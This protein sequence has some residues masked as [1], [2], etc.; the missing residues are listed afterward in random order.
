MLADMHPDVAK[1]VWKYGRWHH[2]VDY[3]PFKKNM[4]QITDGVELPVGAN[5]Y[6]LKLRTYN[7]VQEFETEQNVTSK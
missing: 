4:L 1:V 7:T 3:L 5:N 6:G 2:Y